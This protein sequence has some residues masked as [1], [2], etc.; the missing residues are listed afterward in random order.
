M[1]NNDKKHME[2]QFLPRHTEYIRKTAEA[3]GRSYRDLEAEWKKAEREFDFERM[4]DPLKYS[5]L[6]QTS[7]SIAQEISRR[8]E[9]LVLK[10]EEVIMDEVN[11]IQDDIVEDE[12]GDAI[13]DS[14]EIDDSIDGDMDFGGMDGDFDGGEFSEYDEF[15]EE[16]DNDTMVDDSEFSEYDEFTEE[17]ETDG[18]TDAEP[19]SSLAQQQKMER[20]TEESATTADEVNG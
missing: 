15:T 11:D 20:P 1:I 14:M 8:F 18:E 9:E 7:G 3:T 10:P 17:D 2:Q 19:N 4:R 16:D 6:K 12:F 13:E 5:N